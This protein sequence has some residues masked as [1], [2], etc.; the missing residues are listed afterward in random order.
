MQHD[1]APVLT[2]LSELSSGRCFPLRSA[3]DQ[4]YHISTAGSDAGEADRDLCA[5]V[6]PGLCSVEGLLPNPKLWTAETPHLYTL[7]ISLYRSLGDATIDS[8]MDGD[9]VSVNALRDQQLSSNNMLAKRKPN[10]LQK[11][12]SGTL[13]EFDEE[14]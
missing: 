5:T 1:S 10:L 4:H 12:I 6:D 11:F 8:N 14:K 13:E 9:R 7:I 2:L 3:A